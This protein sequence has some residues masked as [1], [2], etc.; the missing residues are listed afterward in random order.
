MGTFTK[1]ALTILQQIVYFMFTIYEM[2][3]FQIFNTFQ[4][5]YYTM[6]SNNQLFA[7]RYS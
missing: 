2:E 4:L 6:I 5:T 7:T 3:L 1:Y